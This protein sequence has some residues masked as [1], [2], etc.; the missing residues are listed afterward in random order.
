ML[1]LL[2]AK[3]QRLRQT[4][5]TTSAAHGTAHLLSLPLLPRHLR[6]HCN[7][8]LTPHLVSLQ[9]RAGLL[10]APQM[11]GVFY[12]RCEDCRVV[13]LVHNLCTVE[14]LTFLKAR[15]YILNTEW[16][17]KNCT[18]NFNMCSFVVGGCSVR[19]SFIFTSHHFL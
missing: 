13:R 19:F 4:E 11:C 3:D 12:G 14:V 8:C 1:D 10:T 7:S 18:A 5:V 15:Y 2:A 17:K 9:S 6:L 16:K